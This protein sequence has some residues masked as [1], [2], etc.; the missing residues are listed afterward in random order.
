MLA[1][2][3]ACDASLSVLS[4]ISIVTYCIA[5]IVSLVSF[6][7]YMRFRPALHL[8][9]RLSMWLCLCSL[10]GQSIPVFFS[11]QPGCHSD[12]TV[13]LD[14]PTAFNFCAVLG[15]MDV[16]TL[17][18]ATPL[19][20]GLAY[21]FNRLMR[22]TNMVKSVRKELIEN[23]GKAEFWFVLA[24]VALSV[25][26]VAVIVHYRLL[27]GDPETGFCLIQNTTVLSI[28][29]SMTLSVTVLAVVAV[30]SGMPKFLRLL[31]LSR[32]FRKSLPAPATK[33]GN[34]RNSAM[35]VERK[36]DAVK[37]ILTEIGLFL[38]VCCAVVV[39]L[40]VIFSI[41]LWDNERTGNSAKA[42]TLCQIATCD[43]RRD[44]GVPRKFNLDLI[45]AGHIIYHGMAMLLGAWE[46]Q[47]RYWISW[48]NVS[49][50][51]KRRKSSSGDKEASSIL[52]VRVPAVDAHA[53]NR[54]TVLVS[55]HEPPGAPENSIVPV[56]PNNSLRR[57]RASGPSSELQMY[58]NFLDVAVGRLSIQQSE[59][60]CTTFTNP[61]AESSDSEDVS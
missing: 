31:K 3:Y 1:C 47:R 6:V 58:G 60:R 28:L 54:S 52:F 35:G 8:G 25:P 33:S 18:A 22:L 44:C 7:H 15:V 51:K 10:L 36:T 45:I 34:K 9:R 11:L 24:G 16:I 38:T 5:A 2:G 42:F 40:S 19:V 53:S 46:F 37:V 39:A 17:S 55:V 43:P 61:A 23:A 48:Q 49:L 13:R 20:V 29:L 41:T 21:S 57:Q 30:G 27:R 14:E 32:Q 12:G 4:V 26:F 50:P 56:A 59:S